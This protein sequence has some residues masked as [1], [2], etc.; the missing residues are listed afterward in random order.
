MAISKTQVRG[1]EGSRTLLDALRRGTKRLD[2]NNIKEDSDRDREEE[3]GDQPSKRLRKEEMG[4]GWENVTPIKW[5]GSPTMSFSSV[6]EREK[7]RKK[8]WPQT[9][10][11]GKKDSPAPPSPGESSR[12][13]ESGG[14]EG[15][16]TPPS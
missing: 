9:E 10:S 4:E 15:S 1:E 14:K 3:S 13:E 12:K 16:R 11:G 6:F 7:G 5:R 8:E 2:Y